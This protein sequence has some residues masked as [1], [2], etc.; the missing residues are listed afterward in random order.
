MPSPA[1]E[2]RLSLIAALKDPS[3]KA[4][5][6]EQVMA[7]GGDSVFQKPPLLARLGEY[8]L[9]LAELERLFAQKA[10]FREYAYVIPEFDP[11]HDNPRFKALLHQIGLPLAGAG[12]E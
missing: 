9:V 11:L 6:I 10:P 1:R 3:K 7:H 5:A 2:M 8:D 4:A 12:K